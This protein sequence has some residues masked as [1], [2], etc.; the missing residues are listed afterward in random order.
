MANLEKLF[1]RRRKPRNPAEDA[2]L[3]R[4]LTLALFIKFCLLGILWWAFFAGKKVPVDAGQAAR[5]LLDAP[6]THLQEKPR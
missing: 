1:R 6:V 3:A 2:D 4:D 5:A